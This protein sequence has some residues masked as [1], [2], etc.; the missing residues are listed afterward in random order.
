MTT[1]SSSNGIATEPRFYNQLRVVEA[2][3]LPSPRISGIHD[4]LKNNEILPTS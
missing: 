2:H 1:H 4:K 3:A